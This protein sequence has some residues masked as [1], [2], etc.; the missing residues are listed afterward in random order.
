VAALAQRGLRETPLAL[1]V[2]GFPGLTLDLERER[3]SV[4]REAAEHAIDRVGLA[5]LRYERSAG[6]PPSEQIGAMVEQLRQAEQSRPRVV[7]AELMGPVSMALQ[8]TDEQEQPLA[9]D[10]PLREALVQ[11]V[12][13]R[14]A[15]LHDL[16]SSA[17]AAA[18]ICLDEPFLDSLGSPFCPL[19]WDD[20]GDLLAHTLI[21]MPGPRGLCIS[22]A[23]SW[24]NLAA[25]PAD[26]VFFDAYEHGAGLVGAAAS[27]VEFLRRGGT[28][29][30]GIVPT[31]PALLAQERPEPLAQRLF[32]TVGYLAAAGGATPEEIG[33]KSVISTS[34]GLGHLSPELAEQATALCTEVATI[35]RSMFGLGS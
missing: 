15:W 4:T 8:L 12:A 14:A 9:Y 23:P 11:H 22:G 21:D 1:G 33:A 28:L 6:A 27:V 35:T 24:A 5:Y 34:S 3:A 18:L 19:D 17:G 25:L 10:P 20:G 2:A 26:L 7:K 29:G 13:L 31:E 32:T 30:W 16:I